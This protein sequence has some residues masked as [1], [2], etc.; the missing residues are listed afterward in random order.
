[1]GLQTDWL[2]NLKLYDLAKKFR[3]RKLSFYGCWMWKWCQS[4]L[5]L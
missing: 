5:C 4:Y 3:Y 2:L 1:M